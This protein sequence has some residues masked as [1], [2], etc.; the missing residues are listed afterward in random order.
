MS[1]R[2]FNA[3][4]KRIKT[5][6]KAIEII[7]NYY[8]KRILFHLMQRY[9]LEFSKDIAQQFFLYLISHDIG[10]IKN[11]TSW[12]YAC[13]DN[14]AATK[15][16][17]DSRLVLVDD[18]LLDFGSVQFWEDYSDLH[19]IIHNL[20]FESQQILNLRYWQGYTYK[21]IAEKLHISEISARQKHFKI[22]RILKRFLKN[23]E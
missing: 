22:I 11:P 4:L 2:E 6:E 9:G 16:C 14:I 20:T 10:Y 18:E 7:Y 5:D 13:C 21:E 15:V 12:V 1:S 8:Y 23:K 19:K 17:Y 3:L